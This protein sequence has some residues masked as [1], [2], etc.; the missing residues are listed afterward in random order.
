M[1][2]APNSLVIQ[3]A[4]AA[5]SVQQLKSTLL[6]KASKRLDLLG[7]KV[8]SSAGLQFHIVNNQALLAKYNFKTYDRLTECKDENLLE[9]QVQFQMLVDEDGNRGGP[10][11]CSGH[12]Q[13]CF[14]FTSHQS[15]D[16]QGLVATISWL[17]QGGPKYYQG[18]PFR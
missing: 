6:N 14:P 18:P 11:G 16:T 1:H 3:I 15:H 10:P 9:H 12:G 4:V 17:L 7:K 2:L 8:F 5:E 13:Y